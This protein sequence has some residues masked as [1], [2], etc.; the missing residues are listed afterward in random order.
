MATTVSAV[1]KTSS[2]ARLLKASA[3]NSAKNAAAFSIVIWSGIISSQSILPRQIQ[4]QDW[5][6][7]P[8]FSGTVRLK[9]IS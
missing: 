1:S 7:A 9:V 6:E 4:N 8:F 5:K 2:A 3:F